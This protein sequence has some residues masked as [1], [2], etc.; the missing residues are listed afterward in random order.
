MTEMVRVLIDNQPPR[1]SARARWA[2]RCRGW[3]RASS[4]TRTA[5]CPTARPANWWCGTRKPRRA[6]APTPVTST[7]RRPPSTRGAAAGSTP[8]TPWCG[9]TTACSTSSIARRTSSGAPAEN[10]AA[11]EIEALLQAHD[12]VAQVAVIAAP[13]EV[14]EEEVMACVVPAPGHAADEALA[15]ALFDWCT[16]SSRTSRPRAGSGSPTRCRPPHAEDPEAPDRA[17]RHRPARAARHGRP[18][19]LKKRDK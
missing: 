2:A 14:R 5:R 3:R 15:R 7:T 11:A 1:Q 13:D 6:R 16:A 12:A 10:I 9:P 19:V 17:G 4:T 8:A 18:A